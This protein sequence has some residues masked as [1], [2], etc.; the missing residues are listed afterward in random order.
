MSDGIK[1]TEAVP[2]RN[3]APLITRDDPSRRN[4]QK[5]TRRISIEI[6]T[7]LFE[8]VANAVYW[9]EGMNLS[10]FAEQAFSHYVSI[11]ENENDGRFEKRK[12]PV[13]QW[14]YGKRRVDIVV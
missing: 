11:L 8:R 9:T 2:E 5:R 12:K 6:S 14:K 7:N 13:R 3:Q 4:P 10:R 1:K